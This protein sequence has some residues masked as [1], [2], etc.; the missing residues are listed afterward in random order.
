MNLPN[1]GEWL[2]DFY[3][4]DIETRERA[5]TA[6]NAVPLTLVLP[7]L[8]A[9]LYD[10]DKTLVAAACDIVAAQGAQEARPILKQLA[11][12]RYRGYDY[13]DFTA[14]ITETLRAL[15]LQATAQKTERDCLTRALTQARR[16]DQIDPT[17]FIV[18]YPNA[19][20]AQQTALL[21]GIAALPA[22][23]ETQ[24]L[25]QKAMSAN[26]PLTRLTA[27]YAVGCLCPAEAGAQ[28]TPLLQDPAPAV[29][30]AVLRALHTA[31][32]KPPIE[33]IT[34][35][36]HDASIWVQAET[37]A[38][39]GTYRQ[40]HHFTVDTDT[41]IASGLRSVLLPEAETLL[42][43][44]SSPAYALWVRRVALAILDS[45]RGLH[46][47]VQALKSD[48]E[49]L[50]RL[51][52]Y[53]LAAW[54]HPMTARSLENFSRQNGPFKHLA[55]YALKQVVQCQVAV[56]QA[57]DIRLS[58]IV[59][60]LNSVTERNWALQRLGE[61]GTAALPLLRAA[62]KRVG[63]KQQPG[64]CYA[65]GLMG[66]VEDV[67]SLLPLRNSYLPEI[68]AAAGSALLAI[69]ER[70]LQK[71]LGALARV[72]TKDSPEQLLV[73]I[74]CGQDLLLTW[75][76]LRDVVPHT[77][78]G[79]SKTA[80][81]AA[82]LPAT[83]QLMD[84]LLRCAL[85]EDREIEVQ[86]AAA[87]LLGWLGDARAV[88]WLLERWQHPLLRPTIAV[89][90]GHLRAATAFDYLAQGL[91]DY[92]PAVRGNAAWALAQLNDAR[93]DALL[94]QR[95][96]K[97]EHNFVRE[98]IAQA[99]TQCML[100]R[101]VPVTWKE[102][103]DL[104][105]ASQKAMLDA[106]HAAPEIASPTWLKAIAMQPDDADRISQTARLILKLYPTAELTPTVAFP[107]PRLRAK[108]EAHLFRRQPVDAKTSVAQYPV[109]AEV[110]G[111]ISPPAPE[112]PGAVWLLTCCI[113]GA[114][115]H[116]LDTALPTLTIGDR[117]IL[118]REPENSYDANV[119]LVLTMTGHKLGYIPRVENHDLAMRMDTGVTMYAVLHSNP[120]T[121]AVRPLHIHVYQEATDDVA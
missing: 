42:V 111:H 19:P 76:A 107:N 84:G 64:I 91:Y 15:Q 83:A 40:L 114:A 14:A 33:T 56:A 55:H 92:D 25:A 75:A 5:M 47:L 103:S 110:G 57:H 100:T 17:S 81:L 66:T 58:T 41:E 35:F 32:D 9:M 16:G 108:E 82:L 67:E 3:T 6:L 29:R 61:M 59:E 46:L 121:S 68:S 2:T 54:R 101:R 4:G 105:P 116:E 74:G 48:S 88:P 45:P 51:A 63:L 86:R 89:A 52:L 23:P 62:L 78:P 93:A 119:I 117:L 31:R 70:A 65:L 90:V 109:T 120:N 18:A 71:L 24:V 112:I 72:S 28:L 53:R 104:V 98:Q 102:F 95:L 43:N 39:V 79:A 118:R 10:P 20:P 13:V 87:D 12:M 85:L 27:I 50:Q 97:E 44:V 22:T 60:S 26:D 80:L 7:Y 99:L 106:L 77:Q 21:Q 1:I 30:T 73:A 36:L 49:A 34:P 69:G 38:L 8:L 96:E 11:V 113:A 94:A 115:Y 37:V